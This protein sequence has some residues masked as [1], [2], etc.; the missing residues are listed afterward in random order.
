MNFSDNDDAAPVD[1][2]RVLPMSRNV[3]EKIVAQRQ[4]R[5][6]PRAKVAAPSRLSF[7][8]VEIC[9]RRPRTTPQRNSFCEVQHRVYPIHSAP[10]VK[11][12][13][14]CDNGSRCQTDAASSPDERLVFAEAR[15][16]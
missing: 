14:S 1:R 10:N 5:L 16:A 3:V 15:R 4:Y 6:L 11:D 7:N 13:A 9:P 8:F 12:A 2:D